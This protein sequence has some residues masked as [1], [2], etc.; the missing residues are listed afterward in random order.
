MDVKSKSFPGRNPSRGR[1][2]RFGEIILASRVADDP[3]QSLR[4]SGGVCV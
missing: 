2:R 1:L 3:D 4:S